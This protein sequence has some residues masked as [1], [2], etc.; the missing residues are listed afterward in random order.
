VLGLRFSWWPLSWRAWSIAVRWAMLSS[1]LRQVMMVPSG[2]LSTRLTVSLSLLVTIH[3][4]QRGR[5]YRILM[6]RPPSF[7]VQMLNTSSPLRTLSTKPHTSSV[8]SM[9]SPPVIAMS[10]SSQ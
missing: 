2:R 5:T 9:N 3:V 10:S 4:Q 7:L 8:A 1:W 6:L